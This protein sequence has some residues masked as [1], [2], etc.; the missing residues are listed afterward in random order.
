[1]HAVDVVAACKAA[2]LTAYTSKVAIFPPAKNRR[3]AEMHGRPAFFESALLLSVLTSTLVMAPTISH[4]KCKPSGPC[5]TSQLDLG[6]LGGTDSSAW[7]ISSDGSVVVGE[8][9][10]SGGTPGHA[11]RWTSGGMVDLGTLTGGTVSEA[12]D[13]N[14]NGSV[15]VGVGDTSLS[16]T[17]HAFRWTA[18]TGMV[19]L[20]TL[21]G[22]TSIARAVNSDGSVVV[23]GSDGP[24]GAL[25]AFRWT[26]I[27]T[28]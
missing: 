2:A 6:T 14:S 27:R 3:S 28:P 19:D 5:T 9:L 18:A 22:D 25:H 8:S 24:V 4:A 20:G 10:G 17:G 15:V 23:G 7:G 16:Y 21:G 1:M 26:R 13:V 12:F 11:F